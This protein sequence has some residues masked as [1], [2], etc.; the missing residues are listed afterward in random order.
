MRQASPTDDAPCLSGPLL[1][2]SAA[3]IGS[4]L[5]KLLFSQI[6]FSEDEFIY[7]PYNGYI[8]IPVYYP[9][10]NSSIEFPLVLQGL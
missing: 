4:F 2:P 5:K 7:L 10:N 9:L 3:A 1:S 8:K 6:S